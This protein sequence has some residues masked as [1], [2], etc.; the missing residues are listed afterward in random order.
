VIAVP[1]HAEVMEALLSWTDVGRHHDEISVH[2][3]AG[4]YLA[5]NVQARQPLPL[6]DQAVMDGYALGS[7]PPGRFALRLPS[8][9]PL[10]AHEAQ[11]VRTGETPPAGAEAVVMRD[12]IQ[13][14]GAV[15][16]AE[17]AARKTNIRRS[18]EELQTGALALQADD[19]LDARHLALAAMIGHRTLPVRGRAPVSLLTINDGP[20][21]LPHGAVMAALLSTPAIA[22]D[23]IGSVR[24]AALAQTIGDVLVR[25]TETQRLLIVVAESLDAEHG[26]LAVA[27][28][29]LGADVRVHR[30]ALKPA[31]PVLQARL[32]S[33]HLIG[34][35]GTTYAC[36][37]AAHLFVRPVLLKM[38]GSRTRPQPLPVQLGFERM[39]EAGRAEALPVR[40]TSGPVLTA[41]SAGRFGQMS[42]LAAMD[43][44][45]MVPA[46]SDALRKGDSVSYWP[47]TMPLV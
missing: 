21:P 32:G 33:S 2:A 18:G 23:S 4:R 28:Q 24:S 25:P 36:L 26:P 8:L 40:L 45:V 6:Q 1:T 16:V 46:E 39:R 47:V 12:H 35:S 30:A 7:M 44:L 22:L 13:V 27:L 11:S 17:R 29:T 38:I 41:E 15:V 10:A 3:A 43:G 31:K 19:R 34:L 37:V 14:D 20:V 42:A 9:Q 5:E